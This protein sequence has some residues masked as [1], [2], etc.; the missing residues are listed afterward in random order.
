MCALSDIKRTPLCTNQ[1]SGYQIIDNIPVKSIGWD[2]T[3]EEGTSNFLGRRGRGQNKLEYLIL[4]SEQE[5]NY[6]KSLVPSKSCHILI[7]PKVLFARLHLPPRLL[8]PC[9]GNHGMALWPLLPF[10]VFPLRILSE[11]GIEQEMQP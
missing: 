6:K 1:I 11:I 4:I 7:R 10:G 9:I 2:G 8:T 3:K 5:E